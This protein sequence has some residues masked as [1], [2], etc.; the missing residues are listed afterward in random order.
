ML[1]YFPISIFIMKILSWYMDDIQKGMIV[2]AA[3]LI[4][5]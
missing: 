3:I 5:I 4:Y 2:N 1:A